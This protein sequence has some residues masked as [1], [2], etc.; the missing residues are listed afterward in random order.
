[1]FIFFINW[2]LSIMFMF[3][4]HPLSLGCVLLIQ[5][6][7]MSL[8]SGLLYMN[9]WY[10]YILFLVMIG[11]MMVM[12][13]YMTSIASNEKFK[14]PKN[15][16]IFSTMNLLLFI[17]IIIITDHYFSNS[18]SP[19]STSSKSLTMMNFSMS[20]FFNYPNI[21][22]MLSL[23]IYLLITLIAI[24]KITGKNFGTLRQK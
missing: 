3:L 5:T 13:I 21:F 16:I 1:M 22:M 20:K 24:V 2:M 15:M 10:S 19:L 12:F 17:I 9:F 11:G 4:N 7:L 14:M 23:M 8:V 18:I 6:I